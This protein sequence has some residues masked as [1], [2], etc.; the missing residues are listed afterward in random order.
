VFFYSEPSA[1]GMRHGHVA[2]HAEGRCLINFE[3]RSLDQAIE[4]LMQ[5]P[6]GRVVLLTN[7]GLWLMA[8]MAQ[9]V[10]ALI[11]LDGQARLYFSN[12]VHLSTSALAVL[13]SAL[14]ARVL[15]SGSPLRTGW[16]LIGAGIAS[17]A[18]GQFV[19]FSYPLAQRR[20]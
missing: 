17:W 20:R 3:G 12:A 11:G 16:M 6:I 8:V 9:L 5:T 10:L 15:P 14:A 19:F 7:A 2:V 4:A 1:G 13:I 18:I